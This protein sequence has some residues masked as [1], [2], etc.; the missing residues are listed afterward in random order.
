[1]ENNKLIIIGNGFDLGHR[2]KSC[3]NDFILWYLYKLQKGES[4]GFIVDSKRL[5]NKDL[6][7]LLNDFWS[8]D[9]INSNLF[10]DLLYHYSK[11]PRWVDIEMLYFKNLVQI[12]NQMKTYTS[13]ENVDINI[14]LELRKLNSDLSEINKLLQEYLKEIST[15]KPQ[16]QPKYKTLIEKD[17]NPA[18]NVNSFRQIHT[19][20]T[21]FLNFNYTDT[22]QLYQKNY[23]HEIIDIHGKLNDDKNEIIFG[24]GDELNPHYKDMV[25]MNLNEIFEHF[26]SFKYKLTNHY[27]RLELFLNK[28]SMM[29][30]G[31]YDVYIVGHSCGIS[32][33]VLFKTIFNNSNCQKVYPC[34]YIKEDGT[35]DFLEKCYEISRHFISPEE[36]RKKVQHKELCFS[37]N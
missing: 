36:Y 15:E 29:G 2:I 37:L 5:V 8:S 14:I 31:Y 13:K 21:V 33:R 1:M 23:D 25:D 16:I 4:S 34:Y 18:S 20:K 32:D 12:F 28:F 26:K 24:F 30:E 22:L 6:N 17:F 7:F 10:Q 3:Y 35:D 27:N 19:P 9:N 11:N